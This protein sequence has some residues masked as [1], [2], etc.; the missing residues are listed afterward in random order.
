MNA[1]SYSINILVVIY[2]VMDFS[3]WLKILITA[4]TNFAGTYLGIYLMEK[5]R[6]DR[7]WEI[8]GTVSTTSDYLAIKTYLHEYPDIKYHTLTLDDQQGYIFYIYTKTKAES[9]IIKNILHQYNAYTIAHEET[10]T[11]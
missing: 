1:V 3:I 10:V 11:L 5:T 2:T 7:L 4:I 8:S 9:K 6:K